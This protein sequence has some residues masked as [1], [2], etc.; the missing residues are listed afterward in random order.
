[1]SGSPV[2]IGLPAPDI[3]FTTRN[4]KVH[5]Y[6]PITHLNQSVDLTVQATPR[7]QV[8]SPKRLELPRKMMKERKFVRSVPR[9]IFSDPVTGRVIDVSQTPKRTTFRTNGVLALGT[10][11]LA[12]VSESLNFTPR[13]AKT[14]VRTELYDPIT[15]RKVMFAPVHHY[16]QSLGS[17]ERLQPEMRDA[18]VGKRAKVP[19]VSQYHLQ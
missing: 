8:D 1:M 14:R 4:P 18:E 10:E 5:R 6:N 13:I 19:Y 11:S 2:R 16:V 7:M 12:K 15:N 17:Q 9:T 3:R